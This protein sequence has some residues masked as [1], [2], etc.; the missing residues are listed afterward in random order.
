MYSV[1]MKL[2]MDDLAMKLRLELVKMAHKAASQSQ[3][4]ELLRDCHPEEAMQIL[5]GPLYADASPVTV[6]PFD[7]CLPSKISR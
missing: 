2:H 3:A 6:R 7:T 4:I 5:K 1:S